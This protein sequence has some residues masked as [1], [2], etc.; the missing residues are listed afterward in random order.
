MKTQKPKFSPGTLLT[1]NKNE[2]IVL[3]IVA[4]KEQKVYRMLNTKTKKTSI[5]FCSM[6]DESF[7]QTGLV[8]IGTIRTLYGK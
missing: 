3:E 6:A 7:K 2:Y 4:L 5:I 1:I 8:N